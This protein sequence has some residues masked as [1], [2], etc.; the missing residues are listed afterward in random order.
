MFIAMESLQSILY[1][2]YANDEL[3]T[4]CS[5]S[6]ISYVDVVD[7]SNSNPIYILY[8]KKKPPNSKWITTRNIEYVCPVH[9][10]LFIDTK[11]PILAFIAFVSMSRNPLMQIHDNFF[12]SCFWYSIVVPPRYSVRAIIVTILSSDVATTRY[13][14]AG[15][16]NYRI[17]IQIIKCI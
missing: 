16:K 14:C 9:G 13:I 3:N 8:V 11:C 5:V 7:D 10:R 6:H 17:H 2:C 12:S 4:I 1:K 15:K